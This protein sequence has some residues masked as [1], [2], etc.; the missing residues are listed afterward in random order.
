MDTLQNK[1][2]T[3]S[4][5]MKK[6]LVA[7]YSM[8]TRLICRDGTEVRLPTACLQ[9]LSLFNNP[10]MANIHRFALQSSASPEVVN[11]FL[12]CVEDATNV[13]ITEDNFHELQSLCEEL[14]FSG[15]D[16]KLREFD[17]HQY[18]TVDRVLL[19]EERVARHDKL[20]V[21]LQH[22]LSQ[23]LID[24]KNTE[25]KMQESAKKYQALENK[26]E[27]TKTGCEKRIS[28]TSRIMAQSLSECA[29]Q[30]QLSALLA[31]VAQ[32]K[33]RESQFEGRT[34]HALTLRPKQL[35]YNGSNKLNGI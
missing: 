31:E 1:H 12:D 23:L 2:L 15:L 21:Q 22:Q 20:L 7:S 10:E 6:W 17:T 3:P 4:K 8:A 34:V 33:T 18:V 9:K 30:C 11:L 26:V 28:E 32:L 27:E 5:L 24:K 14:G 29:K 35:V 19:L 13:T 16:K 25:T